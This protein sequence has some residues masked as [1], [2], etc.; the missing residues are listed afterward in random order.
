MDFQLSEEQRELQES[1]RRYAAERL[2]P[3]A[4]EIEESG[5]P[6]S[7][8]LVREFADMGYLGIN[9]PEQLGGAGLGGPVRADCR[10]DQGRPGREEAGAGVPGSRS[11]HFDPPGRP[12]AS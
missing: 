4:E 12:D 8:E 3:I 6:P 5:Q 7:H 9:V 10:A 11:E 1:V 2:V